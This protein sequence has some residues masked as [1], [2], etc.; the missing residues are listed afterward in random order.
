MRKDSGLELA[1]S[2]QVMYMCSR[3]ADSCTQPAVAISG[4]VVEIVVFRS[5]AL[6][7]YPTMLPLPAS[8]PQ[9]KPEPQYPS[10]LTAAVVDC[11]CLSI[12][13]HPLADVWTAVSISIGT[14][15]A[16]MCVACMAQK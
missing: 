16:T 11:I 2:L 9:T 13:L 12:H 15:P 6:V 8:S 4:L 14:P 3:F 7:G 10:T 1:I 5:N